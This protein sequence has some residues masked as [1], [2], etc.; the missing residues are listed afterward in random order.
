MAR[1]RIDPE[2]NSLLHR[3]VIS[4]FGLFLAVFFVRNWAQ[5]KTHYAEL[6]EQSPFTAWLLKWTLVVVF[7]ITVSTIA[8]IGYIIYK[9]ARG[10][11]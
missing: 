7:F 4:V 6:R 10:E 3:L 2:L 1:E 9:A 11:L 5:V 8:L